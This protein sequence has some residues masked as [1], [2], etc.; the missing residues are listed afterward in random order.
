MQQVLEPDTF[1][2]SKSLAERG[3]PGYNFPYDAL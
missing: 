3:R 2:E 1:R